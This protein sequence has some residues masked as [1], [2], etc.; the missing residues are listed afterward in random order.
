MAATKKATA[1]AVQSDETETEPAE[2]QPDAPL[3]G[4]GSAGDSGD[5]GD[6]D[7]T[8]AEPA[9]VEADPSGCV[10]DDGRPHVG[11]AGGINGLVCSAHAVHFRSDGAPRGKA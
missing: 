9:E 5:H 11:R 3:E 1:A 4:D 7:E 10:V 8:E 6:A 2:T